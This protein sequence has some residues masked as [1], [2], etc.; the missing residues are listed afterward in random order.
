MFENCGKGMPLMQPTKTNSNER[1]ET[2]SKINIMNTV[3]KYDFDR[4]TKWS[5][6]YAATQ[7]CTAN[8]TKIWHPATMY[9]YSV[10]S[11]QPVNGIGLLQTEARNSVA[12]NQNNDM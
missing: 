1:T 11:L 3:S 4:Y 6:H 10:K 8:M 9:Q 2:D 7:T 12:L 5:P